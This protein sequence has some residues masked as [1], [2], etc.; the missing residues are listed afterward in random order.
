MPRC[1]SRTVYGPALRVVGRGSRWSFSAKTGD[2]GGQTAEQQL[3]VQT[4]K[5]PSLTNRMRRLA[6]AHPEAVAAVSPAA[7]EDSRAR[8]GRG[9]PRTEV[10][11]CFG[12]KSD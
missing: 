7:V 4:I 10:G 11:G 6:R 2:V 3:D 9:I 5:M 12:L 8:Y 1:T